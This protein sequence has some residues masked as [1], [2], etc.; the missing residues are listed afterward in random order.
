MPLETGIDQILVYGPIVLD[1]S[2]IHECDDAKV[3][4]HK[5]AHTK[6]RDVF[7]SYL[8]QWLNGYLGSLT[9]FARELKVTI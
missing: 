5:T 9:L 6:Y 7:Y 4:G 1:G 3:T 2:K 8:F